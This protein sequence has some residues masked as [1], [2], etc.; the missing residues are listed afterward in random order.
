MF[1]QRERVSLRMRA[2]ITGA[3]AGVQRR[4]TNR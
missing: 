2:T 3:E 1:R 4:F